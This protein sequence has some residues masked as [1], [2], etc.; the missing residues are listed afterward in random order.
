MSNTKMAYEN[1]CKYRYSKAYRFKFVKQPGKDLTRP[2]RG[3]KAI[4]V[5]LGIAEIFFDGS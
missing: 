1:I 5:F 3:G 2:Y 4:I